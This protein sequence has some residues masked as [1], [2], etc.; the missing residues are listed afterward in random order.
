[1]DVEIERKASPMA[2][3]ALGLLVVTQARRTHPLSIDYEVLIVY[4][5]MEEAEM[6]P[7]MAG[8][9][10]VEDVRRCHLCAGLAQ[11]LLYYLKQCHHHQLFYHKTEEEVFVSDQSS[12]SLYT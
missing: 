5:I 9:S 6:E 10:R 8:K 4:E 12:G 1:M 11:C 7:D 3:G 2:T